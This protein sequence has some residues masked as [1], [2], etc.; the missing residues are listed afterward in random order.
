MQAMRYAHAH[1]TCTH[2]YT[3]PCTCPP[4]RP[5][6]P[7]RTRVYILG[8]VSEKIDSVVSERSEKLIHSFL[9]FSHTHTYLLTLHPLFAILANHPNEETT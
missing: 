2:T 3:Y 8:I 7:P 4:T 6:L 1:I 9:G 5:R